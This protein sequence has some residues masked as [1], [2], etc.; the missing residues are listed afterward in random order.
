MAFFRAFFRRVDFFADF[1]R[2]AAHEFVATAMLLG[3]RSFRSNLCRR[4]SMRDRNPKE[5]LREQSSSNGGRSS[6]HAARLRR[7]RNPQSHALVI[8]LAQIGDAADRPIRVRA[9]SGITVEK[10]L[11]QI[12]GRVSDERFRIDDQPWF[13]LRLKN[14]TCVQVRRQQR[15]SSR[16]ARQL[17]EEAKTFTDEPCVGPSLEVRQ[18][19]LAPIMHQSLQS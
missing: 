16:C 10:V 12:V 18:S 3:R 9:H 13:P 14:V 7:G 17:F 2:A 15:L 19:L 1:L 4:H 6:L 8:Y 11:R 5:L